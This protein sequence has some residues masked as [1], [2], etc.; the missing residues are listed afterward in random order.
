MKTLGRIAILLLASWGVCA[1]GASAQGWKKYRAGL[2]EVSL[3]AD[4]SC[5]YDEKARRVVATSP[6]GGIFF[7]ARGEPKGAGRKTAGDPLLLKNRLL[8]EYELL[9]ATDG[10]AYDV[11]T[12][13]VAV[14]NVNGLRGVVVELTAVVPAAQGGDTLF[15]K[16]FSGFALIAE[17]GATQYFATILCPV[18]SFTYHSAVMN[19]IIND[20]RAAD[21]ADQTPSQGVGSTAAE[22]SPK[23]ARPLD[24]DWL[25][26]HRGGKYRVEL[27][28]R[29]DSGTM[30]VRWNGKRGKT[31]VV[32]QRVTLEVKLDG[33]HVKG[34]APAYLG[35]A[36]PRSAYTPDTL[37]FQRQS[38]ESWK[39]WIRDDVYVKEWKPLDIESHALNKQFWP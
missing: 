11:T 14:E 2:Y 10:T 39:V 17:G 30:R 3:P 21:T 16:K 29:G 32:E 25:L 1:S 15:L 36:E 24:G 9:N 23:G 18:G 5:R 22:I 33:L 31:F 6:D 19:R 26:S 7:S 4:W 8:R 28:V 37:L 34:S 38:D 35:P 27:R 13:N 12:K 20:L